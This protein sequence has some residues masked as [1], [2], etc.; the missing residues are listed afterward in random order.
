MSHDS[1]QEIIVMLTV[2]CCLLGWLCA[3]LFWGIAKYLRLKK[4]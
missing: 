2:M 3:A 4:S 1:C